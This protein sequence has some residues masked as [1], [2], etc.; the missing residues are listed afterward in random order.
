M[1]FGQLFLRSL[2]RI[3]ASNLFARKHF[4]SKVALTTLGLGIATWL[5]TSK[6]FSEELTVIETEDNLKEGEVR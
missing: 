5:S 6:Y 3:G 1:K 4:S 2:T